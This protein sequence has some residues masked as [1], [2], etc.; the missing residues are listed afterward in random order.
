MGRSGIQLISKPLQVHLQGVLSHGGNTFHM[1]RSFCNIKTGTNVA[2]HSWL[3]VLENQLQ[4]NGKL[5]DTIYHQIDGG[6]ENANLAT[7]AVAELLVYRGL[8]KKVVLTRLPVGH[9]H[10]D[11]DAR[12]GV[13]AAD[14]LAITNLLFI[15]LISD[16]TS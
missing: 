7:I 8:T 15:Q 10:E 13:R 4:S 2:I 5:P 9:T 14:K 11:I 3:A 6:S 1:F 16:S 12:F